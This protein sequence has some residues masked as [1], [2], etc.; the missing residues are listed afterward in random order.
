LRQH[1][2]TLF[3]GDFNFENWQRNNFDYYNL[4]DFVFA[5]EELENNLHP[6]LLR[7]LL[8]Y[9]YKKYQEHGCI[10]FLTTHSNVVIDLFSRNS[11]AQIVH[12]THN[13]ETAECRTVKTYIDNRG[14]LDDLDVRA[15]DL[16]QS[17]GVIWVEGPSDR[18]YINKWIELWS[19][20]ELHEGTH[21]QC[22]FYGGRLL[23]HLS[24]SDPDELDN[25][26]PILNVNRNAIILIDSDKRSQQSRLNATKRRI[27]REIKNNDGIAWV[28]KGKEIEN[29]IPAEAV[30]DV[31]NRSGIKQVG[32]YEDFFDYLNSIS[33]N[34]GTRYSCKKA[35]MAEKISQY[36][37]KENISAVLD[38]KEKMTSIFER[39]RK[40]NN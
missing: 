31:L 7:K 33:K 30:S 13:G 3:S 34:E 37:T 39:I 21:Y 4:S 1:Y 25:G 8:N 36:F 10:F 5:F 12:V 19:D 26:I 35:I 2:F 28:T 20:N 18:I 14:I 29:Y 15:S 38:L 40:W 16:L 17:N 22:V 27:I 11:D 9:L 6:A 32:Q 23:A 24:A